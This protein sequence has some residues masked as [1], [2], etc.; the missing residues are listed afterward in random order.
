MVKRYTA[1]L[2]MED[3]LEAHENASPADLLGLK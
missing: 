2:G 3:A 1:A